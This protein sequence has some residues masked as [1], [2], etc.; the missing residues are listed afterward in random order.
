MSLLAIL[1][2]YISKGKSIIIQPVVSKLTVYALFVCF[3]LRH[4]IQQIP[5]FQCLSIIDLI[6]VLSTGYFIHLLLLLHQHRDIEGNLGSE[7]K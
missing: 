2:Q 7:N 1:L 6:N 3:K 5:I 4:L